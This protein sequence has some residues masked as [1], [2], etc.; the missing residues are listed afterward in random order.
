M[1][2]VV[3]PL[4]GERESGGRVEGKDSGRRKKSGNA[5]GGP[6]SPNDIDSGGIGAEHR[7]PAIANQ[8]NESTL[9]FSLRQMGTAD[10]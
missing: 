1:R 2:A 4:K 3:A 7:R 8:C 5:L 6:R 9:F 10:W